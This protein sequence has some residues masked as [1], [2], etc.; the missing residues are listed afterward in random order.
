MR[1]YLRKT[2]AR[3]RSSLVGAQRCP[4][5]RAGRLGLAKST[6]RRRRLWQ[7]SDGDSV[8]LADLNASR[9]CVRLSSAALS[10]VLD[11]CP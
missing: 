5:R 6:R 7:R 2:L 8:R 9:R 3:P 1:K 4:G 11:M 10:T